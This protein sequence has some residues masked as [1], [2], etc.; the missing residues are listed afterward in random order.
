MKG[1][2]VFRRMDIREIHLDFQPPENLSEEGVEDYVRKFRRH[3]KVDP[4]VVYYDGTHYYLFD[5]FHRV[6]AAIKIGRKRLQAEVVL[7][8]LSD[9][10]AE[11]Q[12]YLAELKKSLAL[13][14]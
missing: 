13:D 4:L 11:W 12:R 8:T 7:G 6:A 3:E 1:K 2:D 14:R 10:E 9:M 5:G